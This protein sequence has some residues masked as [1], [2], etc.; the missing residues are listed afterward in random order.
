MPQRAS[1]ALE[2]R[3][4]LVRVRGEILESPAARAGQQEGG[5]ERIGHLGQRRGAHVPLTAAQGIARGRGRLRR[6]H[7]RIGTTSAGIAR[8]KAAHASINARR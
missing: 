6:G 3:F 4:E 1:G 2:G 7:A 8:Q 5:L